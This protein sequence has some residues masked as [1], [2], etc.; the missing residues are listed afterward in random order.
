MNNLLYI[1]FFVKAHIKLNYSRDE[2]MVHALRQNDEIYVSIQR[3]LAADFGREPD[4]D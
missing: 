2:E 4:D 1:L 3:N